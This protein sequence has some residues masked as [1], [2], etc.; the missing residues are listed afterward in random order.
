[1]GIPALSSECASRT[2]QGHIRLGKTKETAIVFQ[3][4]GVG[5]FSWRALTRSL[6]IRTD[7]HS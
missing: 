1:M 2:H 3:P 7:G 5:A 4:S 6:G